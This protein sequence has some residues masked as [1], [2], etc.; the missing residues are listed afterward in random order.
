MGG[1]AL[2]AD[3]PR[4]PRVAGRPFHGGADGTAG[5]NVV[6]D[7]HRSYGDVNGVRAINGLD[8]PPFRNAF[9][10]ASTDAGYLTFLNFNR[11]GLINGTDLAQFSNRF[12]VILP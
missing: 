6:V 12:G 5:G 1:W 3:G 7:L 9:G 4:G 2:P 8:L 10:T 11:D